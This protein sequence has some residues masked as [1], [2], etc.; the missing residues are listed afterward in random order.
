MKLVTGNPGRRPLNDR[1][2][3]VA[4]AVPPPP[5]HLNGDA[6]KEWRRITR[7]LAEAGLMTKLDLAIVASYC[8]A[9]ARWIECEREVTSKGM[10]LRSPNGL[11]IYSP[12]LTIANRA[13]EQLRQCAEQIGLSGS[14]RS[15]IKAAEV[16]PP[17]D[18]AED[19]LR[20]RA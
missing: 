18:P 15:R 4:P 2:A 3:K 12:Y 6:L 13:M 20:G 10:I 14:A 16:A 11:P 17:S 7:L 9:W 8:V 19:F 5:A 1:E